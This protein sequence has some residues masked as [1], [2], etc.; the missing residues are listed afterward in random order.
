MNDD[1][2]RQERR[3]EDSLKTSLGNSAK[4]DNKSKFSMI[5]TRLALAMHVLVTLLPIIITVGLLA[6]I[7]TAAVHIFDLEGDNIT[8][9][10]ASDTVIRENVE[11]AEAEGG[12]GYYFKIDKELVEKYLVE[13]NKA[14]HEGYWY[15]TSPDP[16]GRTEYVHDPDDLYI[17]EK[18]IIEWFGTED[19]EPYLIKMIRAEIASTYPKLGK[20]EGN[21]DPKSER[22]RKLGNKKDKDGNY[23]AQ[24]IVE[25]QRTKIDKNGNPL[26]PTE[27]EYVPLEKFRALIEANDEKAL[28]CYSFDAGTGIIYY[29]TYKE[30]VVTENDVQTERLY[31]LQENSMSYNAVANMCSMPYNYVFALLQEGKSAEWVMA[32]VDLLLEESEVVLMIQDQLNVTTLTRTETSYHVQQTVT[33]TYISKTIRNTISRTSSRRNTN[34]PI[35]LGTLFKR[36]NISI[37]SRRTCYKKGSNNN[38][39]KYCTSI[40]T[41]STYMVYRF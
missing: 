41:K 8:T 31:E 5:A 37:S 11:I 38:I 19:Y 6:I 3:N 20:Y 12:Q 22:N 18:Q 40:Y 16:D 36:C 32:V 29:A 28:D 26:T 14:F 15:D 17:D 9:S 33:E 10:R 21:D 13:L 1:N 39:H 24:G 23:V 35:L 27:L 34:R 25:I 7:F 4:K 2:E 30:I